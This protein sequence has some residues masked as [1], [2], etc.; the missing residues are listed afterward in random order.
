LLKEHQASRGIIPARAI[1]DGLGAGLLPV[2]CLRPRPCFR[3]A[4]RK[5]VDQLGAREAERGKIRGVKADA[6]KGIGK[7]N[8]SQVIVLKLGDVE[9]ARRRERNLVED[10]FHE[11]ALGSARGIVGMDGGAGLGRDGCESCVSPSLRESLR[12]GRVILGAVDVKPDRDICSRDR[13]ESE[14]LRRTRSGN[15]AA[16]AT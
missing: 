1:G 7:L 2:G 4:G 6:I 9:L 13:H 12:C 5:T 14:W 11:R 15:S 10:R 16:H 8:L 3:I